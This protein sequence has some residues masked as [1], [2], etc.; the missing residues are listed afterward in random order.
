[1]PNLEPFLVFGQP[2]LDEC[3]VQAVAEVLRSRWIGT[4]PKCQQF[5]EAFAQYKQVPHALGLNSCTAALHLSLQHLGVK[6]GDEVIT[7]PVTFA[8]TA[9][10][11]EHL[12]ARPVF[13][14]VEPRTGNLDVSQVESR[15]SERTRAVIVVHLAG[16][17]IEFGPLLD[18][19]RRHGLRIVEDCAHAL[20]GTWQGK[21]L[22]T[23]GDTGCFSFYATKNLTTAEGGMLISRDEELLRRCRISAS[24]GLSA[25]AWTRFSAAGYRHFLVVEPGHKFNLIDLQAAL[26]LVQFEKLEAHAA[27]RAE[28]W[29]FYLEALA[30]L[31]LQLPP[32]PAPGDHHAHHLFSPALRLDQVTLSRDELLNRL[33]QLGVGSGVHFVSLHLHPYYRDKYGY[34]A[35]DFPHALAWSERTFSLPLSGGLTLEQAERV[36][37]ALRQALEPHR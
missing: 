28:L 2:C 29:R 18:L 14:D 30:D 27:R 5:E 15:L 35:G 9:N 4:G 11:I 32:E 16:R 22:G 3:E 34:E 1:M 23:L 8:A 21:P 7:S 13:V 20:E 24:H 25:D 17:S 10:V 26:G 33:H 37:T 19:C 6:P 31:P 36:V 12:G